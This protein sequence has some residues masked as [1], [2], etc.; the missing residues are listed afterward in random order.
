MT[1]D[2][3]KPFMDQAATAKKR[4]ENTKQRLRKLELKKLRLKKDKKLPS[5][6]REQEPQGGADNSEIMAPKKPLNAFL[7]F[8]LEQRPKLEV[9]FG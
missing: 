1:M 8:C 2:E 7:I 3:K 6:D 4:Y 9:E 5:R